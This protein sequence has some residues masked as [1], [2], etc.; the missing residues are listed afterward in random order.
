MVE[1]T[2]FEI[3]IATAVGAWGMAH[4]IFKVSEI[5]N[6]RRDAIILKTLDGEPL[7]KDHMRLILQIDWLPMAGGVIFILVI[8]LD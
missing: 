5:M 4:I 2:N 1:A 7:T 3:F 8:G 6:G